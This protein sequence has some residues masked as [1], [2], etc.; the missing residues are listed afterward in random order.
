[1]QHNPAWASEDVGGGVALEGEKEQGQERA[2]SWDELF[3][4]SLTPSRPNIVLLM[5]V[6]L[7]KTVSIFLQN[8]KK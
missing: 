3:N 1:M 8:L 2:G 6:C 5:S 7:S 4:G